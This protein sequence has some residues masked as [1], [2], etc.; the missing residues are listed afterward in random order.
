LRHA[1]GHKVG[2]SASLNEL[3]GVDPRSNQTYHGS[4]VDG[5]LRCRLWIGFSEEMELRRFSFSGLSA[6]AGRTVAVLT[7]WWS[8][9]RGPEAKQADQR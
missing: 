2:M 5:S 4:F 7:L 1:F 6:E 9:P 8:P 3:Y